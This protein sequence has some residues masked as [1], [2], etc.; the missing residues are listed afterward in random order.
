M[1][2]LFEKVRCKVIALIKEAITSFAIYQ[3]EITLNS[4]MIG[5]L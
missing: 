4:S 5:V 1:V 2:G 3:L